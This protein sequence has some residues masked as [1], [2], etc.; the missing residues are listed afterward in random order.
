MSLTLNLKNCRV[1][2]IGF[3]KKN[4]FFCARGIQ[5]QHPWFYTNMYVCITSNE[6]TLIILEQFLFRF[7]LFYNAYILNCQVS[8][9]SNSMS[10]VYLC[11]HSGSRAVDSSTKMLFFL[12]V[13]VEATRSLFTPLNVT[14]LSGE[15]RVLWT[16]YWKTMSLGSYVLE[17]LW[18]QYE[19][20]T[21]MLASYWHHNTS[22]T[23]LPSDLVFQSFVYLLFTIHVTHNCF[24][25]LFLQMLTS[26]FLNG[27]Y[28]DK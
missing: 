25:F 20:D 13:R 16:E 7:S 12:W 3:E 22:S 17:V 8:I 24:F 18:Y 4:A 11:L 1:I 15:W 19:A 27:V 21:E 23:Q 6:C 14:N 2:I 28:F 10:C 26:V 9:V 5:G